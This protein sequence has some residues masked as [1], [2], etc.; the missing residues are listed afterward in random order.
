MIGAHLDQEDAILNDDLDDSVPEATSS[1]EPESV[2]FNT[3]L[4]RNGQGEGLSESLGGY[5]SSQWNA[6]LSEATGSSLD[7]GKYL[8][9]TCS[10]GCQTKATLKYELFFPA[11]SNASTY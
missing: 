1:Q 7:D 3:L 8:C 10:K 2:Y 5:G 4:S 11:I 6:S 9:P